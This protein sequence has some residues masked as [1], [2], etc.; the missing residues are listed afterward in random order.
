M[1]THSESSS[2]PDSALEPVSV[3][4]PVSALEPVTDRILP[5]RTRCPWQPSNGE[6]D[7][8]R[9]KYVDPQTGEMGVR[10]FP[11]GCGK[12][13]CSVCGPK[14]R[15]SETA[16]Y[17]QETRQKEGWRFYTVT[18][19]APLQ[20]TPKERRT[21]FKKDLTPFLDSV[22]YYSK[23]CRSK[24]K[25]DSR[26]PGREKT[27]E[28]K[29]FEYLRVIEGG[30]YKR[31]HAH[32]L[33]RAPLSP[34]EVNEIWKEHGSGIVTYENPIR[35]EDH[36]LSVIWYMQSQRFYDPE[37]P[38]QFV[39]KG[40]RTLSSSTGIE[41]YNSDSA[42]ERRRDRARRRAARHIFNG[43]NGDRFNGDRPERRIPCDEK[44][45]Q[46][47]QETYLPEMI[48]EPV[49]TLQGDVTGTLEVWSPS[50]AVVRDGEKRREVSP[51]DL[52]PQDRKPPLLIEGRTSQNLPPGKKP[53]SKAA[54]RDQ[55][56]LPPRQEQGRESVHVEKKE[57]GT[58]EVTVHDR[59]TGE[60]ARKVYRKNP[61]PDKVPDLPSGP[62]ASPPRAFF[63]IALR[64]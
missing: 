29:S 2:P 37:S 17:F 8:N 22:R 38:H 51:Y 18:S 52:I 16:H 10:R 53:R 19:A 34:S 26:K 4:E 61:L 45:L 55:D 35:D 31:V 9:L 43:F 12:S 3:S 24:R 47:G 39:P 64:T 60:E 21:A 32:F 44:A 33:Y 54:R 36:L 20:S 5:K 7:K 15:R 30:C 28:E 11:G 57:N 50:E 42:K 6:P 56:P 62:P 1:N 46:F 48:G 27:E 49:R 23:K 14:K 25:V 41:S 58:F 13:R 59:S 40:G 63:L